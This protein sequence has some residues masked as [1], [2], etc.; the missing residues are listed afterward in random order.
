MQN[1]LL[2]SDKFLFLTLV[3]LM[4]RVGSIQ[5]KSDLSSELRFDAQSTDTQFIAPC[6]AAGLPYL[7]DFNDAIVPD[8]PNCTSQ[9]NLGSGN[10]WT[11]TVY[12]SNGMS[13]N[14]LRYLYNT[15]N[16]AN[17]W[18]YTQGINLEAGEDY[19]ISYKHA[20]SALYPENLE[21]AYGTVPSATSMNTT[22][23]DSPGLDGA[24]DELIY[25]TV[26]ADG[27]YYF[28]F[29]A[30]SAADQNYLYIDDIL[31]EI[32]PTCI[33]PT[34]FVLEDVSSDSFT[35]SWT[36]QSSESAWN[37]RYGEADT[38]DMDDSSTY[39]EVLANGVAEHTFSG[40]D[41]NT[42]YAFAVQADCAGDGTSYWSGVHYVTTDCEAQGVPYFMGFDTL[43]CLT[44]QNAGNGNNW[45]IIMNNIDGFTGTFAMYQYHTTQAGNSW[46]YMA[47]LALEAGVDYQI[48]YKYGS[49]GFV[50]SM[51]VAYGTRN[52]YT[53]MT[54]VLAD[55]PL[56]ITSPLTNT[57]AFTVPA[58]DVY[59]F[60]FNAYSAADQFGLM[61]DDILIEKVP[62][63]GF[64]YDNGWSP[65][66]PWDSNNPS[67]STDDLTVIN[68][69]AVFATEVE[70]NDVT[71]ESGASL[72][73]GGI[74]NVHGDLNI[75]GNLVFLSDANE[76][77]ELGIMV[78]SITGDASIQRYMQDKRS[79]RMVSSSVTT[80]TAIRDNWQEA[81][82]NTIAGFGTHITGSTTGANGFDATLTGNP[83]MF[84]VDV[85]N[86]QFVAID[87]T[88][89]NTLSVGN[90][91]LL[92]VRGDRM[93][94]LSSNTAHS[95]TTLRAEGTLYQ[96]NASQEFP[97]AVAGNFV[98]VGNPY[99]SAVDMQSVLSNSTNVVDEHYYMYDPS[100]GTLGSYVTVDFVT[101]PSDDDSDA[102]QYLQPGQ[103]AQVK[104]SGTGA[105]V[106]F[107]EADKAPGNHTS[108]NVMAIDNML[109]TQL[110]T[111]ENFSTGGP[112]HDAFKMYFDT[113]FSNALTSS[114]AVKP[115]NFYE[116]L[117]IDHDGTY[118]SIEYREMPVNGEVFQLY[119]NGYSV[120][121]YTIK[122]ILNGL[123]E[124]MLYLVD[125][126][127]GASILLEQGDSVTYDFT[128]DSS[129]PMSIAS[130]RFAIRVEERLGVENVNSL[131][132]LSLYPNPINSDTFY[133]YAPR[134]DGE[135]VAINVSDVGGREI[136]TANLICVNNK[137]AV[138]LNDS[139][140]SGMYM[141][142]LKY[143]GQQSTLRLIKE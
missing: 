32:V 117:G 110:Y 126:H 11:T 127:T 90:P 87:N 34:D 70:G 19:Q 25:F 46:L 59:Y 77:G 132:G 122:M 30:Y 92:F 97:M 85:S 35:I 20:A 108:T 74:L 112:S 140:S 94:D 105:T 98:M 42:E 128:V 48:S 40:L 121:D 111:S 31:I 3:V 18:F 43:D 62:L 26:P 23:I 67:T 51:K 106:L 4:A 52:D 82:N 49:R 100:L 2:L 7:M 57:V 102:N 53:A 9:E 113:D 81:G 16:A 33:T 56:I 61:L 129:D 44:I 6:D 118:L 91:Y 93:I 138:T 125:Y 134:L 55:H 131:L 66:D 80:T 69:T 8:L 88:N 107:T 21:V 137:I 37:V 36:A 78:G 45:S 79:Y 50:E 136:F 13:G 71:I 64:V 24:G 124:H 73:V 76:D 38:F 68:G 135:N 139:L 143:D 120:T 95:E 72:E 89:V 101:G 27:V 58:D 123:E 65:N 28:G 22:L 83:S 130:D 29:H 99:Q 63:T 119:S 12:N 86:Q 116:N 109:S 141:V 39:T 75:E 1:R 17:V 14:V 84:T 114:D 142:T 10:N 54:T 15:S 133:I 60:G 96:G 47:P 5:A 41:S 104:A 115:M 103:G